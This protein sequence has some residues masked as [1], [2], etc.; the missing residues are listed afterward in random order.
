V[1]RDV[2][3]PPRRRRPLL[4]VAAVLAAIAASALGA[5]PAAAQVS[6][7]AFTTVNP[8]IDGPGKC[9]NGSGHINCN[10]YTGKQ[11]VWLN[12]GPVA[13]K[14]GPDGY[15]F[16]VVLVPSGQPKPNDGVPVVNGDTNLSDDYDTYHNRTFRVLNGEVSSYGGTHDFDPFSD[17]LNPKIRLM[18][19]S[20]TTNNGGVYILAICSLG[21]TGTSY[22]VTPR[23]CKYDAFKIPGPD[24]DQPEC[25][26]PTFSVNGDGQ[27]I[28][29]QRF[30]DAGGI[31]L[32]DVVS[33]TNATWNISPEYYLGSVDWVTLVATKVDQTKPSTVRIIVSDVA[34]NQ[35]ECDPVFTT[36]RA[37][38]NL[39]GRPG[40]PSVVQRFTGLTENEDTVR[41]RNAR[42]G[43]RRVDVV[44]NGKR[45]VAS[46]LANGDRRRINI[47]SALRP[48]ARNTV[49]LRG[50]GSRGASASV[51]ISN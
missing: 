40:A 4:G 5:G 24:T 49:V 32:I 31:R 23:Q 46:G 6:G 2:S 36:L 41:I 22:P 39:R 11:Y 27:K 30:R 44:V 9:M 43:L 48:G 13:N 42:P 51:S 33:I 3:N 17:P 21:P 1:S 50:W 8:A 29:T 19:Y 10:L 38:G 47:G 20:N 18:P 34:G 15:Y 14:I 16:F 28:A 12:G 25:P 37:R 7:A 35:I 45:F 26:A